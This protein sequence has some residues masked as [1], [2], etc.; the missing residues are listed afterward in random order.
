MKKSVRSIAMLENEKQVHPM[1]HI[2][3]NNSC[4][5]AITSGRILFAPY[6]LSLF[7][8]SGGRQ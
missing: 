3:W 7:P 5:W 4:E 6:L 1:K 2:F 8:L